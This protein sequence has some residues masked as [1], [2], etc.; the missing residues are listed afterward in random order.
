MNG[1]N[2]VFNI[3]NE[4]NNTYISENQPTKINEYLAIV[5]KQIEGIQIINFVSAK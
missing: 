4:N 2:K 1:M 5:S 3:E